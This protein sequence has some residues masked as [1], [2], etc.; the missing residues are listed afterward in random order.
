MGGSWTAWHA[1][2]LVPS[3]DEQG[4]WECILR[5]GPQ[6]NEEFQFVRDHDWK[7]VI[8]PD[9]PQTSEPSVPA[10]GP[11]DLGHGKNWLISGNKGDSVRLK[12]RIS[13][14]QVAVSA[15]TSDTVTEWVS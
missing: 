3:H 10:R 14:G 11:D 15:I 2:D 7:Q 4:V 9:K 8:Y 6:Q 1:Q 12:L 13:D 5:I